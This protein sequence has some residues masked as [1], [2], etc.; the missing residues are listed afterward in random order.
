ML[1]K[2]LTWLDGSG[3]EITEGV[4][5]TEELLSDGKRV[6]AKSTLRIQAQSAHHNTTFTCRAKSA[7]EKAS[8]SAEI[9]IEVIRLERLLRFSSWL[10]DFVALRFE[11]GDLCVLFSLTDDLTQFSQA[12]NTQLK[13]F[14][15]AF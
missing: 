5:K 2:Q 9:K 1:C 3:N 15:W 4:E 11:A 6:T 12:F 7:A 8:K 14:K 10:L 13:I